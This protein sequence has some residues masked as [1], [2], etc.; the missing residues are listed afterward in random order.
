[1]PL[2]QVKFTDGSMSYT[3]ELLVDRDDIVSQTPLVELD[4]D[5]AADLTE[6]IIIEGRL[7][8]RLSS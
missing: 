1:M 4:D 3:S 2:W 6:I 5:A 7:Y 8:T